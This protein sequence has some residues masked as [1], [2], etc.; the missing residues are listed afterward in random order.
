MLPWALG[1]CVQRPVVRL[2]LD[3]WVGPWPDPPTTRS[4][5]PTPCARR[6]PPLAH[7]CPR[8]PHPCPAPRA[9]GVRVRARVRTPQQASY[10]GWLA[11]LQSASGLLTIVLMLSSK[12]IF[13]VGAPRHAAQQPRQ[14]R[15]G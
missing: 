11:D 2:D 12:V 15:D 5:A 8:P 3:V 4:P 10:T 14:L 1:Q 7:L 9:P 13:Q 6:P